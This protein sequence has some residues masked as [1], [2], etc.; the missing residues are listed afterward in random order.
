MVRKTNSLG[1][2]KQSLCNKLVDE[3]YSCITPQR[4]GW[5]TAM[6]KLEAYDYTQETFTILFL[7]AST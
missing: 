3:K 5:D 7:R 1:D 2:S 4:H 6:F